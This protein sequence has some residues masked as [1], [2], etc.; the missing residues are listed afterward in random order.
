MAKTIDRLSVQNKTS[1][2][3][4]SHGR[5]TPQAVDVEEAVLG[6]MML[7]QSAV[8]SVI[9]VLSPESFYKPAHQRI[10]DIIQNLFND[11]EAI[12]LLTVTEALRKSGDLELV[13]GAFA[14]ANL[15]TRVASTANVEF[16]ARIVSQKYIQR[17]LIRVS[18]NI[19]E[20]AF[21]EKTDV[22]DLLDEAESGLFK[23]APTLSAIN[24]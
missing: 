3:E 12:D 13:G 20:K 11:S 24:K 10:F 1:Y 18:S 5:V 8:N 9:D 14:V 21:D 6:A 19:I 23:V 16:H 7:E 4:V 15:T 2:P 22:F 17:E